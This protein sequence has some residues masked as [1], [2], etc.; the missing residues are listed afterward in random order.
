LEGG[1]VNRFGC[2]TCHPTESYPYH[3]NGQVDIDLRGNKPNAGLL[4]R[5]NNLNNDVNPGYN[6]VD[7]NNFFCLTVYCHSNGKSQQGNLIA[8]DYQA[9]P[10]WYNGTFST[11]DRCGSCH[12]NP[13]TYAGQSHYVEQSQMGA[14]GTGT[15]TET[16]HMVGIHF[17]NTYVGN[18]QNG[19]L[20]YSSSGNKAHGNPNVSTTI[21]CYVCHSGIVSS[22]QLDTYTLQAKTS[23][24]FRCASC[25]T[26]STRTKLQPGLIVGAMWHVNGQKDVKFTNVPFLTKA[27]L[28]S[29]ANALGWNR[30]NGYKVDQNSFDTCNLGTSTWDPGTK[31]CMTACHVNQPSIVWGQTLHCSSCHANQ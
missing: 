30:P 29:Q 11:P 25:H 9:T 6:R 8:S 20:G 31:T 3:R 14:N 16:G 4:A 19:Y 26:S 15:P 27:Q 12:G 17:Q 18:N 10:N 5:L 28:T 24:G 2:A 1:T 13:P 21:G 22:A 7:S 23:S